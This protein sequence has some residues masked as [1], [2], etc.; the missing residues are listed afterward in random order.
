MTR[1]Q[2]IGL[3]GVLFGVVMFLGITMSGTTPDSTGSGAAERYQDYWADKSNSDAA[4]RGTMLLTYATVLLLLLTAGLSWLVRR[5]DDGPLP[6]VVLAGGIAS[7][8]GFGAAAALLNGAGNAAAETGYEPDGGSALLVEAIGYYTATAA[9]MAAAAMAV[10][11]SLSNRRARVVPQW[12]LVLS[13]LLGLAGLGSIFSAWVGFM[14]L[15]LW[16]VVIGVCLLATKE[17]A[18]VDA[19]PQPASV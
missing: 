14:L 4:S 10:A 16:A 5:L 11:F 13:A 6:V 3:A 9:V 8:A 15:P 1:R 19:T 12:T 18:A 7:A 2:W 17:S